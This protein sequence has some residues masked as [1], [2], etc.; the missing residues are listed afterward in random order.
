MERLLTYGVLIAATAMLLLGD[1]AHAG[2]PI[3]RGGTYNSG[4]GG[5]C[6]GPSCSGIG[7]R[8]PTPTTAVKRCITV[9]PKPGQG[10][11]AYTQC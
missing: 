8:A 5:G 6:K 11:H 4:Y 7:A 10:G 2:S 1:V 3:V 9:G